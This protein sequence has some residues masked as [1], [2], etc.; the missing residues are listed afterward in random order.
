MTQ[1]KLTSFD[2]TAADEARAARIRAE[3]GVLVFDEVDPGPWRRDLTPYLAAG[4][5]VT[6]DGVRVTYYRPRVVFS[7]PAA[8][9][10]NDP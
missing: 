6:A 10:E 4:A 3:R 2:W 8:P 9:W 1:R 7:T 5:D